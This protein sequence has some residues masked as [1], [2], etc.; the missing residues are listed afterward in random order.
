VY[1]LSDDFTNPAVN[2]GLWGLNTAGKG[3]DAV[4]RNGR[5]EFS[6]APDAVMADSHDVS[7]HYATRC[8]LK[9]DFDARVEYSLLDWPAADGVHLDLGAWFPPPK[10]NYLSI[11]RI[12]GTPDGPEYYGSNISY[13][14]SA[15]TESMSGVLRIKRTAGL[16][17][18]YYRNG[19]IWKR[20]GW[21]WAPDPAGVVL[22]LWTSD[23][24]FGHQ[25]ATA[26]V[27]NFNAISDGVVCGGAPVPPRKRLR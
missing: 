12:G 27:D 4:E 7:K 3:V 13:Q 6:I 21:R 24:L 8:L 19:R 17:S 18:V 9:G 15:L 10:E 26:A 5:L 11:A 23:S 20:L 22:M 16:L 2:F 14:D 1:S 25:G